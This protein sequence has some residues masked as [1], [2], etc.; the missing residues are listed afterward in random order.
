MA[1][2]SVSVRIQLLGKIGRFDGEQWVA[3]GFL[4]SWVA[5][6]AC[7]PFRRYDRL[8][9]LLGPDLVDYLTRVPLGPYGACSRVGR[10]RRVGK[11]TLREGRQPS[12]IFVAVITAVA[13]VLG[14]ASARLTPFTHLAD[15][16]GAERLSTRVV[17]ITLR[18]R[19][20]RRLDAIGHVGAARPTSEGELVMPTS[21]Q[22]DVGL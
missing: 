18:S 1:G 13:T 17:S 4:R 22:S 10:N 5:V 16:P 19:L 14:H 9:S 8:P 21:G 20:K 7:Q 3:R 11:I 15:R 2:S 6:A 12:A